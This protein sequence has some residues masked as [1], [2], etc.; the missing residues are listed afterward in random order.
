MESLRTLFTDTQEWS[1]RRPWY[2]TTDC[3]PIDFPTCFPTCTQVWNRLS[4]WND[5]RQRWVIW[6]TYGCYNS[7]PVLGQHRSSGGQVFHQVHGLGRHATVKVSEHKSISYWDESTVRSL[8]FLTRPRTLLQNILQ[9]AGTGRRSQ[10]LVSTSRN[11]SLTATNKTY[12][13]TLTAWF[14]LGRKKKKS[15]HSHVLKGK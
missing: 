1:C 2:C 10:V 8:R 14:W 12:N 3:I 13:P 15:L 11:R 4:H 5:C 6:V 7:K 9:T